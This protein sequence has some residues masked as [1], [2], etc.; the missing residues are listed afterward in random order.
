MRRQ[1]TSSFSNERRDGL[2]LVLIGSLVFILLG[3]VLERAVPAPLADFRTIYYPSQALIEQRDPFKP[4][5]VTRI[6]EA[7]R[8]SPTPDSPKDRQI[9]T[10][11]IYP[12]NTMF[13]V[14]PFAVLQ[15]KAAGILWTIVTFA[16]FITASLLIW[17]L[18]ADY[19]PALA[20][21]LV[22]LLLATSEL[23]PVTGNVAGIAISMS[24][25]AVWCFMRE[26]WVA[27]GIL[28]LA[29]GLVLKPQDTGMVW[30]CFML[31]DPVL[32]KR[33]LKSLLVALVL[34]LP[35][36]VWVWRVAPQWFSEWKTNMASYWVHG[37]LN[38]PGL[39]SSGSHGLDS[40]ISLQTVF[41]VFNDDAHFYNAA[42]EMVCVPLLVAWI[43]LVLRR[44]SSTMRIWMALAAAAPLT[45]LP[46]YHRQLDAALLL[47]AVPA[48][49]AL[50][51]QRGTAGRIGLA[52]TT[53]ALAFAGVFGGLIVLGPLRAMHAPTSQW[54]EWLAIA[55]QVF[56]APLL[57]L[58]TGCF[59][60][61]ALARQSDVTVPIV[62]TAAQD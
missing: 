2:Y 51:S 13:F 14:M 15:S 39:H 26:R 3:V 5:E 52:I 59:Y 60:L 20:G 55:L 7:E 21:A 23:L 24:A 31:S 38:D 44:R 43:F 61:W 46:V 47:L 45:M 54:G 19:A 12:P 32:R 41:S 11:N 57:L 16:S 58:A 35:G 6:Y 17:N 10:H 1:M 48:C 40:L 18:G 49:V 33:A 34:S 8:D 53:A 30:L 4:S 50:W 9:A 56:P 62:Q 27:L 25:I 42:A 29:V 22:G 28:C 37:G 36:F